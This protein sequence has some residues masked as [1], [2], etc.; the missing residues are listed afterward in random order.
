M[1]TGRLYKPSKNTLLVFDGDCA[2]C[3]TWVHRLEAALPY[4]PHATPW[5]W[6][7]LDQHGLSLDDVAEYAWLITP[8]HHYAGHLAFAAVLRLQPTMGWRFLGN[9]MRTPPFSWAAAAGYQLI[10]RN[11]HRLP[12][13]TPECALPR[14]TENTPIAPRPSESGSSAA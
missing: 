13:G 2:F 3:T 6:L 11:R 12:G 5:Q 14:P 1:S 7:D 8:R 9:L 4:F 10:A